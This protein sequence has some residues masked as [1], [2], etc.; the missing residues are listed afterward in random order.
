M[1]I[2][3]LRKYCLSL[4]G[5]TEDIKWGADLCFCIGAKMFAVTG[6]DSGGRVSFKCT[7]EKFA[8]LTE[9]DGIDPAAYVGRYGWVYVEKPD[10]LAESELKDL[11]SE[12]Y[13]LVFEKLPAKLRKSLA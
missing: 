13:R 2:E 12:S 5:A 11:I 3:Q 7:P 10:A 4:P 9:R 1:N 8:E 6:V